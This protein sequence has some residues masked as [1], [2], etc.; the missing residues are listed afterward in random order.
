[1]ASGRAPGRSV[2]VLLPLL[3]AAAGVVGAALPDYLVPLFGQ[4]PLLR[5]RR[6]GDGSGLGLRRASSASGTALFFALGG[7]GDGHVPHAR[8][9]P[10]RASTAATLPD[11][12]VFLDWKELPWYWHGFQ[13][14]PFA[15]GDGAG[16]CRACWRWCS[17]G[18]RSARASAASTSRSSPRRSPTRRCCC[19]SRTPP[20]SA[21][22]TASPTSSASSAGRCTTPRRSADALRRLG[23]RAARRPTSLCRFVVT[24]RSA[25]C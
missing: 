23:D 12:M 6:A 17:A 2:G 4:V 7:Y 9:S 24:S 11:F 16:R 3:N 20:A 13:S 1:M 21:A 8:R 5:H 18:S 14:F 10:A 22:T 19:S 25:A 15:V